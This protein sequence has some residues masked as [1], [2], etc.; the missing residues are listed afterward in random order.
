MNSVFMTIIMTTVSDFKKYLKKCLDTSNVVE[1]NY[2]LED[3]ML[4]K[5]A[6]MW[7]ADHY[8]DKPENYSC[9]V[10]LVWFAIRELL[11]TNFKR[12]PTLSDVIAT[13]LKYPDEY[14]KCHIVDL[15]I[16]D[17]YD[18]IKSCIYNNINYSE[19]SI[20]DAY[21]I[22]ATAKALR[23]EFI[24]NDDYTGDFSLPEEKEYNDIL[25]DFGLPEEYNGILDDFS[26][27]EEKEYN[28]ILDDGDVIVNSINHQRS[29]YDMLCRL[30]VYLLGC[31]KSNELLPYDKSPDYVDLIDIIIATANGVKRSYYYYN[32]NIQMNE[33]VYSL[34]FAVIVW[35]LKG[36]RKSTIEVVEDVLEN[37]TYDF[38]ANKKKFNK[39]DKYKNTF[40]S[41][42]KKYWRNDK[43][44]RYRYYCN[45]YDCLVRF[46]MYIAKYNNTI[47]PDN[48]VELPFDLDR[49]IWA[50]I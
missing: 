5:L 25:A 24:L 29:T 8:S 42:F 43:P 28:G 44:K 1:I 35:T 49:A 46:E 7:L 41:T 17:N 20:I 45:I 50:S 32:N 31:Y 39:L 33:L 16:V 23:K 37:T 10:Y 4:V 18:T 36:D 34:W 2:T 12:D 27:P 6:Y 13:A 21:N 38:K 22:K 19:S 40:K 14:K 30:K 48:T 26:L 47:K 3:N 9:H 11:Q 15:K